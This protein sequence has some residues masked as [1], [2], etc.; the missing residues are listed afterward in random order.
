MGNFSSKSEQFIDYVQNI[1][2][3]NKVS[4]AYIIELCD[5]D[6]DMKLV[7]LFIKM[8][9]CPNKYTAVNDIDCGKC[10]I[11]KLVDSFNYPDIK[12][13]EPDGKDIKKNQL[14]ELQKDYI[15]KSLLENKR[16]YIIKDADKLNLSAANTLLKFL[17]EPVDDVIAILLTN[18]RYRII[19]TVLSRCQVLTLGVENISSDYDDTISQVVSYIIK[20]DSLFV[21]YSSL[22]EMI[23]DKLTAVTIFR[24]IEDIFISYVRDGTSN[25]DV[26]NNVDTEKIISFLCIIE[27]ELEKL[28]YNVNF[29]LW[30]DAL[31]SKLIGG[32]FN[33]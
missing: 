27:N 10:N 8:I 22:L 9:L 15:N 1:V 11:C 3:N 13:I 4:H 32:D 2:K 17:E 29:K 12:Y 26:L 6:M 14:I 25:Y 23:P 7:M 28:D 18:N 5:Y 16:I 19:E 21:E 33:D 24:K 30:L 31:F 20:K